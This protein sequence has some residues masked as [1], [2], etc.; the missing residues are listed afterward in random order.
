MKIKP[1]PFCTSVNLTVVET[2]SE[3]YVRCNRCYAQGPISD[4][5]LRQGSEVKASAV[6]KW[7]QNE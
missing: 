4:D 1:C 2:R 7:N 3:A 6:K 5:C